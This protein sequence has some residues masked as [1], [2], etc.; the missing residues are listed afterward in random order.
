[1]FKSPTAHLLIKIFC[2]WQ[3]CIHQCNLVWQI[4]EPVDCVH[5][6]HDTECRRSCQFLKQ[7]NSIRPGRC[8]PE[9][10]ATGFA[11]ICVTACDTDADCPTTSHKCCSNSCGWTCQ[12][13]LQ[14]HDGNTSCLLSVVFLERPLPNHSSRSFAY[15]WACW[16]IC[17]WMQWFL[18]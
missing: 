18:A 17:K 15:V 3:L 9:T 1:M 4:D 11:A 10:Q 7:V 16:L 8:P 13:P 14:R 12:Q 6:R 5:Q 2:R